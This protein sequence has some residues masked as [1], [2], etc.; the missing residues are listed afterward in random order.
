MA[1]D[2]NTSWKKDH[3]STF[4]SNSIQ[5]ADRSVKQ[6]MSHPEEMAVEHAFNSVERAESAYLNAEEQNEHMDTVQ[7]NKKQLDLMKK[8]I[9]EISKELDSSFNVVIFELDKQNPIC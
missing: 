7:Q 4:F 9:Q 8:Q 2:S 5:K 1:K 3:P 6:A